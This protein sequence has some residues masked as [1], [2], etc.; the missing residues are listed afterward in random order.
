M[1]NLDAVA[2]AHPGQAEPYHFNLTVAPGEIVAITGLSGSGKSTLLDLI[3]G[4][5]TP[6][7]GAIVFDGADMTRTAPEDRPVSVLFQADNLFDHLSVEANLMLGLPRTTSKPARA[8][9]IATA[10]AE[11]GLSSLEKRRAA[12]LSGGQKQRVALA[13]TLLRGKSVVL[14][15]EPFTALDPETA[16]AM[17]DLVRRLAKENNWALVLVSHD[18]DD[19]KALATRQLVIVNLRLSEKPL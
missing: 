5:L 17:R 15:D 13:R 4:F 19:V 6:A 14:L 11:V 16:G 12:N 10:L 9:K 18:K 3:A 8:G 1:L 7:S 2:F